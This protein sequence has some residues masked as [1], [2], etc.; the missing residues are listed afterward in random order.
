MGAG[1][2]MEPPNPDGLPVYYPHQL[3]P[4]LPAGYYSPQ[5]EHGAVP[6]PQQLPAHGQSVPSDPRTALAQ[7]PN[8]APDAPQSYQPPTLMSPS[9][10]SC[11]DTPSADGSSW[12]SP[13]REAEFDGYSYH[14]SPAIYNQ[15]PVSPQAP[16]SSPMQMPFRTADN[17]QS[18]GFQQ[19]RMCSP[20]S[21]GSP[22]TA[23]NLYP[24]TS[25]PFGTLAHSPLT[26]MPST[27]TASMTT[28]TRATTS[29]PA[30]FVPLS[31]EGP[32]EVSG[33]PEEGEE[34][35]HEPYSKQL[36]RA[37]MSFPGHAATVQQIYDWFEAN[38]NRAESAGWKNSI[39]HNLSLNEVRTA[40]HYL[41]FLLPH[42]TSHGKD[43]SGG[44][45]GESLRKTL[46]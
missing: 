4:G 28:T 10:S 40:V 26:S 32:S 41:P 30:Q 21:D 25:H 31:P 7:P 6:E 15:A 3:Q 34:G 22:H 5:T 1:E 23:Q 11:A 44:G 19:A 46:V 2:W 43:P 38:T 16:F 18:A 14:G 36:V 8:Q 24:H 37:L 29:V 27:A 20:V 12:S 9:V 17:Q 45:G 42:Q 39:R 13:D 35:G 33:T